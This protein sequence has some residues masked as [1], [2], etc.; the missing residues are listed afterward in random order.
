MAYD[1]YVAICDP[2][3]YGRVMNRR[4][5]F[6]LATSAWTG[7]FLYG[8]VHTSCTFLISFCSN[9]INQFFCEVPHLLILSCS[10][11][12]LA[13]IGAIGVSAVISAGCFAFIVVSY[14]H[15]FRAVIG[16]TSMGGKRKM[17]STCIPHLTVVSLFFVLGMFEHLKPTSSSPSISDLAISLMYSV[18]QPTMNPVIYT[19]RNK[20]IK[21]ALFKLFSIH[22]V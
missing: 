20:E 12:Y 2:L 10:N 14:I 16:M 11:M 17:F 21:A 5:C 6:Q 19:M 7:G 18:I 4:F 3:N 15:I 22:C 9:V 8:I 13:E 1:R